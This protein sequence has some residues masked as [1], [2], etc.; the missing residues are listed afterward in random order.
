MYPIEEV[1][2]KKYQKRHFFGTYIKWED[3][4]MI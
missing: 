2:L 4:Q 3:H 1:V